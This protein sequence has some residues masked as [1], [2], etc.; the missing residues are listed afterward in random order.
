M[1]TT[2]ANTRKLDNSWLIATSMNLKTG[3]ELVNAST[4]GN[5]E[6]PESVKAKAGAMEMMPARKS[7]SDQ[8]IISDKLVPI[9]NG[10][11]SPRV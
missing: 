10:S 2:G 1:P 7:T 11:Q 8:L 5:A 3:S 6:V 9:F 4:P